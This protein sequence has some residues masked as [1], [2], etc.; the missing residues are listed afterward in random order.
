M[1]PED[2]ESCEHGWEPF[3]SGGRYRCP[4]CGAI[5]LKERVATL[6]K[7]TNAIRPYAC[8]RCGKPAV[9]LD[10]PLKGGLKTWRC[11]KHR[12]CAS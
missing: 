4:R 10:A 5:G 2:Q 1:R 6:M 11:P 12:A 7:G 9:G 8:A 3:G